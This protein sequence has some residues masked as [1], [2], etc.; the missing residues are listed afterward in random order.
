MPQL[1]RPLSPSFALI[2]AIPFHPCHPLAKMGRP[3]GTPQPLEEPLVKEIA[4]RVKKTPAQ[5]GG[6]WSGN[7]RRAAIKGHAFKAKSTA[8]SPLPQVLLRWGLQRGCSVIPKSVHAGEWASQ[9]PSCLSSLATR[10]V[11]QR[12]PA[13]SIA[14]LKRT[15]VACHR[16]YDSGHTANAQPPLSSPA[17]RSDKRER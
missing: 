10:W 5:V 12:W 6:W 13:S 3:P 1:R 7:R 17:R 2:L 16:Y 4:A 14:L 9:R 11:V 15:C 8:T